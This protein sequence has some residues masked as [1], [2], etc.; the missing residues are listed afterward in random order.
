M[1]V[2]TVGRLSDFPSIAAAMQACVSGDTIQLERRYSNETATIEFSGMTIIGGAGSLGIV[3]NLGLGISTVTLAG[4]APFRLNDASDGNGIVANAGSNVISVSDGADAVDGGLGVDRLIV[5]YRNA[6]QAV[7]GD[8]TSHF[9][10]AGAGR[11]VSITGGTFEHFKI[12]TGSGADTITTGA[13][14]DFIKTGQGASTVS[15]GQGANTIIGGGNA[16]TITALDGGNVVRAGNGANTVTTGGGADFIYTGTGADTIVS[17]GRS[18]TISLLGGADTVDAGPGVD[19]LVINYS[20]MISNVSGGV[21]GSSPGGGYVGHVADLLGSSV[22]FRRSESFTITTGSG[23]DTL[24]TGQGVDILRGN[25]G[26]DKFSSG[27]GDDQLFGGAGNDLL[28]G[29]LGSDQLTGGAGADVFLFVTM[30]EVNTGSGRDHIHDFEAGLDQVNLS[31]IDADLTTS[32]DQRFDFIGGAAFS[33][34]AGELRYAD[35]LVT[36]DVDGDGL[37]DFTIVVDAQSGMSQG[38]FLL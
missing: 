13:G 35:G 34:V 17:G 10:E 31:K 18:D 1:T 22:D 16:D 12:L 4:T 6:T 28:R 27:G 11:T 37:V 3:L 5:D 2:H 15:A 30:S 23:D 20:A 14:D 7:T 36:G 19:R 38:D 8:S 26:R 21:T 33:S 9:T 32:G 24:K 25:D 29:G